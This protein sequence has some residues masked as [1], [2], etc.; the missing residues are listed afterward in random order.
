MG[1]ARSVFFLGGLL[2]YAMPLLPWFESTE[3]TPE[4]LK[5]SVMAAGLLMLPML[6]LCVK[7]VPEKSQLSVDN[8]CHPTDGKRKKES[9]RSVLRAIFNNKPLRLLTAAHTCTGFG[10]SMC[11]TLLFF[12]ADAYLGLGKEFALAFVISF[13]LSIVTLKLWYALAMRWGKQ[14]S[15]MTG[16]ALVVIGMLCTLL[17]SPETTGW[18]ELLFCM[19]LISGGF[20]AFNIMVP[21]LLSDIVDYGTWQSGTNRAATYF[22]LYTFINKTVGALGGAA[23]LAIAGWYGFEPTLSTHSEETIIGLRLGFSWIPAVMILLSI[24]FINYIPI[25]ARNH[26][27]ICRRLDARATSSQRP[28]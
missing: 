24:V 23:G 18:I 21:S 7:T 15:W 10:S 9:L 20:A 13:G 27:A 17:L 6:Y 2:F 16:M 1:F 4:T 3:F 25:T 26:A 22:S 8:H 19:T 11:Y 14:V 28:I 12:F 5:W